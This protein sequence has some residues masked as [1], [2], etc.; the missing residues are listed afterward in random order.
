MLY[1]IYKILPVKA[2]Q[3][4]SY[5]YAKKFLIGITAIVHKNDKILLLKHAYQYHWTLPGGFLKR[6]EPVYESIRRELKEETGLNIKVMGVLDIRNNPKKSMLDIVVD[7]KIIGGEM[8]VD[9]KEIENAKFY[10]IDALPKR[11]YCV[12]KRLIERHKRASRDT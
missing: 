12:H 11:I 3:V 9:K 4:I 2:R 1:K 5:L 7:C 10:D 8:K 6:S